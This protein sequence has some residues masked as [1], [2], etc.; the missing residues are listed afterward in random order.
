MIMLDMEFT[1]HGSIPISSLAI[2]LNKNSFGLSPANQ[3]IAFPSPVPV[4]GRGRNACQLLVTPAM[5]GPVPPG[6]PAPSQVQVAVKNLASGH[7]FYFAVGFDLEALFVADGALDRTR[8]IETWKGIDDKK[9][10]YAT[11]TNLTEYTVE[12]VQAKFAANNIF[13]IARRPV[14]NTEGHEVVYFN[15]KTANDMLFLAE[16]T[17]KKG[18]NAC[19]VCIKTEDV[20]YGTLAKA[21]MENLLL[22]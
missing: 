2:Q 17:F 6:Q 5:L 9:E 7:V 12:A 14:P 4:G 20:A 13:F 16:L 22:D 18:I 10:I 8:F 3:Q 19:K 1:N 11:V 21:A 15:M